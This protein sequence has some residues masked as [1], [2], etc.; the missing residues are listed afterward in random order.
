MFRIMVHALAVPPRWEGP[1]HQLPSLFQGG[2]PSSVVVL[3]ANPLAA[4]PTGGKRHGS[5][6][7]RARLV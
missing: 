7:V 4:V 1:K 3:L 5:D 6:P 2:V